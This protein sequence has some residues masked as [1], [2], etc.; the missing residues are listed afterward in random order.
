MFCC[1][2]LVIQRIELR[3]D[4]DCCEDLIDR[5]IDFTTI[6]HHLSICFGDG[7]SQNIES[8]RLTCTIGSQQSK[9]LPIF[10]SKR[11]VSDCYISIGIFFV[12]RIN[13]YRLGFFQLSNFSFLFDQIFR[14]IDFLFIAIQI[15]PIV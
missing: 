2:E 15:H 4:T 1:C 13:N 11:I 5:P 6:K 8:C 10:N 12:Q 7:C 3:A 14:L 9:S